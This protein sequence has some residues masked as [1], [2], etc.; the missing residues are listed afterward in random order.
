MKSDVKS[1]EKSGERSDGSSPAP[2]RRDSDVEGDL[3]YFSRKY[4]GAEKLEN[5][6]SLRINDR[7][8]R[9]CFFRGAETRMGESERSTERN[10]ERKKGRK[11]KKPAQGQ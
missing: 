8:S 1:G 10:K 5:H 4:S 7:Q 2:W 11:K 9:A 6:A 3:E